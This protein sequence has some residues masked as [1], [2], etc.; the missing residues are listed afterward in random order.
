MGIT[1]LQ[2]N[3]A[4]TLLADYKRS[5]NAPHSY[6]PSPSTAPYRC[7]ETNAIT[8]EQVIAYLRIVRPGSVIGP[9]QQYLVNTYARMV[10][11]GSH[12]PFP[13]NPATHVIPCVCE[14][15]QEQASMCV[16]VRERERKSVCERECV[17]VRERDRGRSTP[18]RTLIAA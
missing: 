10:A 18:L 14:R 8:R 3:R 16:C 4:I 11:A 5:P 1:F 7:N 15:E 6:H 9:Q 17:C 2:D 12:V 13:Y